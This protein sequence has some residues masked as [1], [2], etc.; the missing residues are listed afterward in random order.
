MEIASGIVIGPCVNFFSEYLSSIWQRH[1]QALCILQSLCEFTCALVLLYLEYLL[2]LVWAIS[3][4]SHSLSTTSFADF[5]D[6]LR[7]VFVQD[8]LFR[9]EFSKGPHSLYFVFVTIYFGMKSSLWWLN[10]TLIYEIDQLKLFN[11]C[12][13][14]AEQCCLISPSTLA[15]LVS[16]SW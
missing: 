4:S 6:S 13:S 8:I 15:Y 1:M 5:S 7:E 10:K 11:D 9:T 16:Y 3:S 12:V 14:L 2:S